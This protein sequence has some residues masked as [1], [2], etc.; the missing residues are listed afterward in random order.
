ML[1]HQRVL[2]GP[3]VTQVD[4]VGGVGGGQQLEHVERHAT[5]VDLFEDLTDGVSRRLLGH[6]DDRYQ[7]RGETRQQVPEQR[8]P[9]RLALDLLLAAGGVEVAKLPLHQADTVE[10][11]VGGQH[12]RRPLVLAGAQVQLHVVQVTDDAVRSDRNDGVLP[13]D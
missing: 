2:G 11:Q 1:L 12:L 8:C 13:I 7:V 10:Q 9:L 4:V 3:P 6:H 5:G